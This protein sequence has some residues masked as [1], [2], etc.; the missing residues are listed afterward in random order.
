MPPPCGLDLDL[1]GVKHLKV[2]FNFLKKF[3][4]LEVYFQT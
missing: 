1:Q 2:F 4:H 3:N